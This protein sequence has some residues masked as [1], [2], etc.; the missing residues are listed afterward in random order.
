MP[1]VDHPAY[2]AASGI[3]LNDTSN[4]RL[5]IVT[6]GEKILGSNIIGYQVGNEPDLYARHLHRPANY[7]PQD[8]FNEFQ[9]V[10][11]ALSSA[12][13]VTDRNNLIGPSI[14]SA[15]WQPSDVWNTGFQTAF[16]SQ[17]KILSVERYVGC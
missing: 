15:D 12:D 17:L 8:Y 11:K 5:Q 10:V 7:T 13:G 6:E 1:L 14:A 2:T 3:P 9:T 16:G 4:L